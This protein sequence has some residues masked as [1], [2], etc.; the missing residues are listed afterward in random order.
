[1]TFADT[2]EL[3]DRVGN[4]SVR[5]FDLDAIGLSACLGRLEAATEPS[6]FVV[7]YSVSHSPEQVVRMHR[8]LVE[9][10]ATL[11]RRASRD[12]SFVERWKEVRQALNEQRERRER[13]LGQHGAE[14]RTAS[15]RP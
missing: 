5:V 9:N 8:Q 12:Q 15:A 7:W 11:V 13:A 6:L 1:M 4:I 14:I 2:T 3:R 10:G